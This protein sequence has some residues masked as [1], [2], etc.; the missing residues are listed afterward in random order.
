MQPLGLTDAKSSSSGN[1]YKV[2]TEKEVNYIG[3][4]IKGK[5]VGINYF[6]D[7]SESSK[8]LLLKTVL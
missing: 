7:K 5:N 4:F 8:R 6:Y 1:S 3:A 2:I